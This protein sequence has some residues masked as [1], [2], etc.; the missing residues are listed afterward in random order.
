MEGHSHSDKYASSKPT[1]EALKE[2]ITRFQKIKKSIRQI[3][4]QP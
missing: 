2:E 4:K 3:S 1:V